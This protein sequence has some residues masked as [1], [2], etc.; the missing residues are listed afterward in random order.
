PE[1]RELF[2]KWLSHKERLSREEYNQLRS[3]FIEEQALYQVQKDLVTK[4]VYDEEGR[5]VREKQV[6]LPAFFAT[7]SF[8]HSRTQAASQWISRSSALGGEIFT[9]AVS[10][11]DGMTS[12]TYDWKAQW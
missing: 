8:N 11:P 5:L 7:L 9:N 10:A 6:G 3:M 2:W 12:N 4:D 1:M